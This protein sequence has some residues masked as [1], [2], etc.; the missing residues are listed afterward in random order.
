MI[1]ITAIHIKNLIWAADLKTLYSI[2]ETQNLSDD[3]RS[4]FGE[5]KAKMLAN[6]GGESVFTLF[7][8]L[9][10]PLES[11]G[12]IAN[13]HFFYTPSRKGLGNTHRKELYDLLANFENTSKQ[14]TLDWLD[15]FLNLH[16]FEIS[17]PGLKDKDL[18]PPGKTGMIISFL[19][20]YELFKKVQEAGWLEEFIPEIEN[21]LL[22]IIANSVF[23]MLKDR[24]IGHFSFSPLS[25]QNRTGSSEGAIVGWEF[26]KEMPVINK[27][28]MSARSVITPLPSVYQ[29][30]QWAYSPAGVPMSILTGKIAADKVIKSLSKK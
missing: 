13:G 7:L 17:I 16:T 27:I 6:K 1:S 12:K 10:E 18:A 14:Q 28:Q 8:Q 2:A 3:I 4:T 15:K 19:A 24:V 26:K 21:R 29:A 23:P 22:E 11:F 5:A 9:D 25:I 20:D 30:G